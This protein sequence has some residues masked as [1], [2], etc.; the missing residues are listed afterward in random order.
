MAR[1]APAAA[2]DPDTQHA[3]VMQMPED[4]NP[5]IA[6]RSATDT[7][8]RA[9]ITLPDDPT[10]GP[11][12]R[13]LDELFPLAPTEVL[14]IAMVMVRN[15]QFN[16]IAQ[17][18]MRSATFTP[19]YEQISEE[20]EGLRRQM[21]HLAGRLGKA[22]VTLVDRVVVR[23]HRLRHG[24]LSDRYN[25]TVTAANAT[26]SD[27]EA[28]IDRDRVILEAY[29]DLRQAMKKGEAL[30]FGVRAKIETTLT[31]VRTRLE[32]AERDLTGAAEGEQRA[33]AEAAREVIV[34]DLADVER[35]FEIAENLAN[36]LRNAC[37]IGD[38][39]MTRMAQGLKAQESVHRRAVSFLSTHAS[40]FTGIAA[41]LRNMETLGG[42]TKTLDAMRHGTE[43]AIGLL[44]DTSSEVITNALE[45]SH[46]PMIGS[47]PVA[48]VLEAVAD[49][50]E[51]MGSI[52]A[53]QR[54]LARENTD[55]IT[56][57][58]V[59]QQARIADNARRQVAETADAIAALPG[60]AGA[61]PAASAA[62]HP[63]ARLAAR[64]R[65]RQSG[66]TPA[67]LR[68]PS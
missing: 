17:H 13:Q 65:A 32:A 45:T 26:F 11:L 58:A 42:S 53:E 1:S 62:V 18:E 38:A 10:D 66:K 4:R 49:L 3:A 67:T 56:Q 29:R 5:L 40:V 64:L 19:R 21:E 37:N 41:A 30:A 61:V 27:V 52:V 68:C 7:I 2:L 60:V 14:A 6:L 39:V 47:E 55:R 63:D 9:G 44:A 28:V 12:V 35:Q 23:Y 8:T 57:A 20:L 31:A 46:G 16:D 51:K 48:R 34:S 15:Q 59:T 54:R 33:L 36:D 43:Q 24:T 22:K 25:A 50:H